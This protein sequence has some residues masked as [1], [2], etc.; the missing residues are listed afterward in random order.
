MNRIV[1][2]DVGRNNA[3]LALLCQFPENIKRYFSEHRKDFRRIKPNKEG[4]SYLESLRPTHLVM[5]PTGVHYSEIWAMWAKRNDV[6]VCWV[7]HSDLAAQ[8]SSYGFKNKRDDED[9]L[10][11]AATWF[12]DRFIDGHGNRRWLQFNE[13]AVSDL[14]DRILEREQLDKLRNQAI[15]QIRQRLSSEFPEVSQKNITPG[16]K[17]FSPLLGWLAGCST[18]RHYEKLY[19]E[20]VVGSLGIKISE[21][22]KEHA[23]QLVSIEVR[24]TELTKEIDRLIQLPEFNPYVEVLRSFNMGGKVLPLML[25]QIYPLDQWLIDGKQHIEWELG[26]KGEWQKRNRS[27]KSFQAYMGLAYKLKQ[28]GDKLSKSFLGSEL[29]RA[30][31]YMWCV[32][33]LEKGGASLSVP[34]E[35]GMRL[36]AKIKDLSTGGING[37]DKITRFLFYATRLLWAELIRSLDS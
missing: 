14:R 10:C 11:L 26:G 3:V 1:G 34:G 9:A 28:S 17:G 13:G 21:Y 29:I 22:T 27:L 20:S 32:R 30:H 24:A 35:V 15:N 33:I 36:N 5:E 31:L 25:T 7:G 18:S 6:V 2:L 16:V 12:D 37:T 19:E 8:R 4:F 23:R